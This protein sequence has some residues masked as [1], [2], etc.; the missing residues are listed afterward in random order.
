LQKEDGTTM[1]VDE[2]GEFIVLE[3]NRNAKRITVSHMR[4]YEEA[5][6]KKEEKKP[7]AAASGTSGSSSRMM[8]EVNANIEKTTFGD[9]SV[10]SAL[11]EQMEEEAGTKSKATKAKAAAVES[12]KEEASEDAPNADSTDPESE[13]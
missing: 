11:K 5:P 6:K 10:L 9:L 2:S 3:F 12:P 8:E 7:R 1:Q 13:S 4:T